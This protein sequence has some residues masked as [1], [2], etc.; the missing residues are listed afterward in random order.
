VEVDRLV[1]KHLSQ[2]ALEAL[3]KQEK[4]KRF[5][6]RLIF[7]R[8]LYAGEEV[9]EAI[10]KLGHCRAT[11][12]L[13]LNRWN[14]NGPAGLKPT[15]GGGRPSKLTSA[16]KEELK[17]R[18]QAESYWTTKDVQK[19]IK[20]QFDRDYH[21]SN[22]IRILRSLGMRYAK[23][24]PRD[25]RRPDDAEAKLKLTLEDTLKQLEDLEASQPPEIL[26]N[27]SNPL[28]IGFLD[29]CSPQSCANTE[30][31]WNFGKAISIKDTTPYRANTFGFYA[32]NGISTAEFLENSKKE[33]VCSFLE[34]IRK[35]NPRAKILLIL[36]N[37]RSHKANATREKA[38]ELGISL[39]FLPPY[40]PDLNPIEQLWRCL[41]REL[42][43]AIF[44][45]RDEFLT[46]I[47][48]SFKRLSTRTSFAINWFQKFF[49]WS[50]QLCN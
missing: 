46:V 34:N 22:V 44:R 45:S 5:A 10:Q 48:A 47:M 17:Q 14:A 28:V 12:Y 6:E 32:P 4:S 36:D 24:Y 29:E 38:E 19:L 23:P 40:S 15:F 42:S 33:N 41:K 21:V 20:D 39:M 50:K 43:T 35:S 1:V 18:L 11:G 31:V 13:W 9:E 2:Q 37:F 3:I 25:Y 49:P 7:I 30:R 16:Q 27:D 26:H 8:N